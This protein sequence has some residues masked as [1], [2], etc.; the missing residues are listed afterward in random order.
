[1][2]KKLRS[3]PIYIAPKIRGVIKPNGRREIYDEK[4]NEY[5]DQGSI[6]DQIKIYERQ[7][8][9][10]FLERASRLLKGAIPVMK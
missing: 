5:L 3:Y 8:K 9:E 2:P 1:M 4:R 7:V 10:W 6:D